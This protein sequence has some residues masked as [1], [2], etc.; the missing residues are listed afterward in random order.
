MG[1]RWAVEMVDYNDGVINYEDYGNNFFLIKYG[2][3]KV[4][5]ESSNGNTYDEEYMMI[6][7]H[8]KIMDKE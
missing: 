6:F 2:G 5:E 1:G 7:N 3:S 8:K 4:Q